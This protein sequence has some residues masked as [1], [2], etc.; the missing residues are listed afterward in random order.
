[1]ITISWRNI[2]KSKTLH[3]VMLRSALL[4]LSNYNKELECST[5]RLSTIVQLYVTEQ[6]NM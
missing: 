2:E 1:M 5:L 4:G 6:Y 3:V